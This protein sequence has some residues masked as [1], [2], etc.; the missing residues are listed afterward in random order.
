MH[1]SLELNMARVL[2]SQECLDE[3][4]DVEGSVYCRGWICCLI[5]EKYGL[6][7]CSLES[8]LTM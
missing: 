8:D 4:T 1:T 3:T 2:G 6:L 5:H 7:I